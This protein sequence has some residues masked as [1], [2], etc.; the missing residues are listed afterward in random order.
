MYLHL[1]YV[2]AFLYIV[3][4]PFIY[5]LDMWSTQLALT[6]FRIIWSYDSR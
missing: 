6:S 2:F 4:N 5:V 1:I 3:S